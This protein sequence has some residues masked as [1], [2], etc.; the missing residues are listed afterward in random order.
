M[1]VDPWWKKALVALFWLWMGWAAFNFLTMDH[2]NT[3][4]T[5]DCPEDPD[6]CGP[7]YED[8]SWEEQ[9]GVRP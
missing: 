4:D 3:A 2:T 7:S 5:D 9:N 8:Y 6:D 1:R